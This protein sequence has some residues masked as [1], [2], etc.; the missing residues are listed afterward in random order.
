MPDQGAWREHLLGWLRRH[1]SRTGSAPLK[2]LYEEVS[3]YPAPPA[4]PGEHHAGGADGVFDFPYALPLRLVRGGRTLSFISTVMTFNAFADV[5]VSELAALATL[6]PADAAT[7]AGLRSLR[8]RARGRPAPG[9]RPVS[10]LSAVD[11]E[12]WPG[13][14]EEEALRRG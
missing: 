6:L 12:P 5:A 9:G 13:W 2:A 8:A 14:S 10:G 7:S 11:Q 4:W 1:V 3:G